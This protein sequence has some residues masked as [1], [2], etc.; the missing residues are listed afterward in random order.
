M[1]NIALTG[2]IGSG[3]STVSGLFQQLG[4]KILS[5]DKF[6]KQL[7][8]PG[9]PCYQKVIDYFG[10]QIVLPNNKLDRS[11][12]KEQIFNHPKDKQWLEQLLHPQIIAQINHE[13]K[14]SSKSSPYCIIEI[15][16]LSSIKQ[17]PM[18]HR[19]LLVRISKEIQL[20][21]I[22]K[23]DQISVELS[24]KIIK[25][26]PSD[27]VRERLADDIIDNNDSLSKLSEQVQKLHRYYLK[28]SKLN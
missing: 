27:A 4:A 23:R 5:A 11:Q 21:R 6:G 12:I 3:K 20:Q 17:Y 7:L 8:E 14:L 9:Q 15:P 10:P 26:Q 25:S 18:I 19:V 22:Q 24:H 28:L 13:V 2:S 16:L 1:M